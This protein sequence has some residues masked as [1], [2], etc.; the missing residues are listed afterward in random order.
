[1]LEPQNN[2]KMTYIFSKLGVFIHLCAYKRVSR[3]QP[4][5][6]LYKNDIFLYAY[7]NMQ[8]YTNFGRHPVIKDILKL[9]LMTN[10][11]LTVRHSYG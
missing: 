2:Y 7:K 1:M 3:R 4:C 10:G 6:N 5:I 9:S 11:K 8:D